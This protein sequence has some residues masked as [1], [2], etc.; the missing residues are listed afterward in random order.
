M[1]ATGI[2]RA[3]GIAAVYLPLAGVSVWLVPGRGEDPAAWFPAGLALAAVLLWGL[4]A[5]PGIALGAGLHALLRSGDALTWVGV[6]VDP[7]QAALIGLLFARL[8]GRGALARAGSRPNTTDPASVAV[9]LGLATVAGGCLAPLA[10][11]AVLLAYGEPFGAALSLGAIEWTA[12]VV[13]IGLVGPIAYHAVDRADGGKGLLTPLVPTGFA[14]FV[15]A[16]LGYLV[17]LLGE[18]GAYGAGLASLV[19]ESVSLAL[20]AALLATGLLVIAAGNY[21][22]AIRRRTYREHLMAENTGDY[23]ALEEFSRDGSQVVFSSPSYRRTFG[24]RDAPTSTRIHDEDLAR[25]RETIRT[26]AATERPAR[27]EFRT[28]TA[29]GVRWIETQASPAREPGSATR[30]VLSVSRDITDRKHAE[31]RLRESEE[32]FRSMTLLSSDW[33]WEQDAELRFSVLS[34]QWGRAWKNEDERA[35]HRSTALGQRRWEIEGLVPLS[36]GWAVHRATLEARLPFRNFEYERRTADGEVEYVSVTGEPFFRADGEFAGYRGLATNITSRKQAELELETSRQ[37]YRDVYEHAPMGIAVLQDGRVQFANPEARRLL[38][39]RSEVLVCLH[40]DERTSPMRAAAP[41]QDRT[42]VEAGLESHRIEIEIWDNPG[43]RWL[44]IAGR[45]ILWNGHPG[46]ITFFRDVTEERRTRQDL[47]E[48]ETRLRRLAETID[49]V[50]WMT[51]AAGEQVTFVSAAYERIWGASCASLYADARGVH[52]AVHEDDRPAR[53]CAFAALGAGTAYAIEYRIRHPEGGERWIFERGFPVLDAHGQVIGRAGAATDITDRKRSERHLLELQR[54]E[55][56]GQLTGGLAHDFNNLLGI[57]VG[58]L[59]LIG[60]RLPADAQMQR[61]YRAALDAALRGAEVTRALLAAARRQ[62]L[63]VSVRDLN[64][65]LAEMEPLVRASAGSAV[66]FTSDLCKDP[67]EVPLDAAGLSNVVLNLV[68]NARDAMREMKG[69]RR[70]VLRTRIEGYQA[71]VEVADNGCGMSEEVRARAFEPFFTT[72]G[73]GEGTG[74]GLA[75][76][77]GYAAQLGGTADIDT[78]PNRGTTVA[79]RLPI[80]STDGADR[81][82]PAP[83]ARGAA[84]TGAARL[85]VL[86]VDDE[87][88]LCELACAWLSAMGHAPVGVLSPAEALAKLPEGFDLLFTDVVMPGSMD[89]LA[90]AREALA[91]CPG[92]RVLLASG[93]AQSLVDNTAAMP[94]PLLNKPYRR[95]DLERM[96]AE[97]CQEHL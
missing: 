21:V 93:Y 94:G 22:D 26:V 47:Q 5:V 37:R 89:G 58:N 30:Y 13:G 76:V 96:L 75:M 49:E 16:P 87:A 18:T 40:F 28:I 83:E 43:H 51:D 34:K 62:P 67:I 45:R 33:Y 50:F 2:L 8:A 86:V 72:K 7:A 14:V 71:V 66:K 29:G 42:G 36:C 54:M 52:N 55:A 35:A 68:L 27:F 19:Q 81:S 85:R 1:I 24:S 77:Q 80:A 25:L 4:R 78:V 57:V 65:V 73:R 15:L 88:G 3:A 56:I 82:H 69:E 59:D 92:I 46:T 53:H 60:E 17:H 90:L 97:A 79:V 32:R 63:E 91:R 12:Q 95:A 70:L 48:S 23:L 31:D 61:Q 39:A 74:L 10:R 38:D 11:M 20:F 44:D 64:A 41:G 6:A 9:R 84:D